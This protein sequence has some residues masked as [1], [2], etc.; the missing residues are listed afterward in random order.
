MPTTTP[1]ATWDKFSDRRIKKLHPKIRADAAV[2]INAVEQQLGI[3]L[4]VTQGLRTFAEQ[5]DLFEQGRSKPGKIVTNARGG[6][7]YHNFGLAID[8]CEIR[9]GEAIWE[10]DW[11]RIAPVAKGLGW[12]WGGDWTSFKDRPHFQKAFGKST[13]DLRALHA[14]LADPD[15]YVEIA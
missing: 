8:V 11:V 6:E 1:P 2:L 13:G 14:A 5:N 10:C 9:N 4:R 3:R 15:G 7:S 12:E